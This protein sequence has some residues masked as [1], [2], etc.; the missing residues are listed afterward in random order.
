MKVQVLSRAPAT[1]MSVH[2]KTASHELTIATWNIL[3]DPNN[4]FPDA[5]PQISRSKN[6]SQKLKDLN[7]QPSLFGLLEVEDSSEFGNI[8]D[9]ITREVNNSS[10]YWVQHSRSWEMMGFFGDAFEAADTYEIADGRKILISQID[11]I[12]IAL[13]HFTYGIRGEDL[14]FYQMNQV[15]NILDRFQR[16]V[17]MGDF[18]SASWQKSRRL[19]KRCNYKSVFETLGRKRSATVVTQPYRKQLPLRYRIGSVMGFAPDDIYVKNVEV[20]DA[21]IF[22]GDSDHRGVWATIKI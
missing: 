12:A 14:R 15:L 10:G 9:L 8:G 22:E 6:I 18:N 7:P 21:G 1:N 20:K 5:K 4:Y 11:S 2:H 13:I 3:Y 17:L 16:V 19:A